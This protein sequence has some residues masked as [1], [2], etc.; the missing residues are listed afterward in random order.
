MLIAKPMNTYA[1][2]YLCSWLLALLTTPVVI[3]L[4]HRFDMVD[5]PDVRKVHSQPIP[6]IGGVA[7]FIPM[8]ALIA[9]VLFLDNAIGEEFRNIQSRVI[10]L[11]S[12]ATFMFFVG[13]IDDIK[14]LRAR[15]K[16]LCQLIAATAV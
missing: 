1:F 9:S 6:R 8:M 12:A 16:L 3:R 13:L 4:A 15:V 14:G 2:V 11:L 5:A 10:I 7:V